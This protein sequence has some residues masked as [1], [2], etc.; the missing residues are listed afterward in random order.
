MQ[1]F[2]TQMQRLLLG[3]WCSSKRDAALAHALAERL[4]ALFG[5]IRRWDTV[6]GARLAPPVPWFIAL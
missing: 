4:F 6:A 3:G 5:L 2:C 1:G